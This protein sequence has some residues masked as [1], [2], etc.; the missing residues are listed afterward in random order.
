MENPNKKQK[1][2]NIRIYKLWKRN[3]YTMRGLANLFRLSTPRVFE[4]IKE[5]ME[6]EAKEK[7]KKVETNNN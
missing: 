2:R 5:Y 3:A 4:I 7:T 6:N 1:D